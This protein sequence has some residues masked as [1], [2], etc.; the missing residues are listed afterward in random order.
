M[1]LP[2][3]VLIVS[4]NSGNEEYLVIGSQ[5]GDPGD[6]VGLISDGDSVGVYELKER[7]IF[8]TSP[9]LT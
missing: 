4:E 8:R 2:K 5:N 6:L 9:S 3:K 1:K 7:K